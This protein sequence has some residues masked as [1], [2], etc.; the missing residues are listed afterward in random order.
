[1]ASNMREAA[2]FYLRRGWSVFPI[3]PVSK[4]P[5]VDW[6]EFQERHA[7]EREIDQWWRKFPSAGV[8]I[9]TGK[10]SGLV[11][12]DVDPK[13]GADVNYI[14]KTFPSSIVAK[15]GG[16]GGHFYYR[17]PEGEDIRNSVGKKNGVQTG[18]DVRANGGYVVAP[19]SLHPSGRRYEWLETAKKASPVPAKLLEMVQPHTELNGNAT[20]KEPWLADALRG[21]GEGARDDTA[22]RLAGY[23]L[24]K[25][26][27][28]DVVLETLRNWNDKNDPPL[29]DADLEKVVASVQKTRSRNPKKVENQGRDLEDSEQDPL[30]LVSLH[31]YMSEYGQYDV[32][33]AVEG[34]LP[35]KTIAMMVSP[36][37]TYKTWTLIDLAVSIA[38]GTP[39]LGTA[40]IN[41]PGP[42]LIYQQEDFHGQMAQRISTI[43]AARFD[44]G[45]S[46]DSDGKSFT[47]TLPPSPPIYLHDNRELRFD[48]K[49][50]MD[51]LE[52]R[53]KELHP[54][55]V[56]VDPLYTAA[57][58]DDYMAKAVPHMMRLKK[59]RDRY[60]C[61]FIIAHH[62]GK[63][64]DKDKL[65]RE[66]IWGSQFL[67]AFLET[68]WQ[69]RPKTQ[70][71]ALIRRH[72]KVT[73]D[74]EEMI[75]TFNISTDTFPTK[76]E[77][78][79]DKPK[80]NDD[81]Q[82]QIMEQLDAQGPMTAADLA[83]ATGLSRATISRQTRDM[84][85]T[86]VIRMGMDNKY[87][88]PEHF[89]VAEADD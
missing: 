42:V 19:P 73:K 58:M 54:V 6:Y 39:F 74:I 28:A 80:S 71:Q 14:Y 76:Y 85:S 68:G 16:G 57:P 32:S 38:T 20:S 17:Y 41:R 66:D 87:R 22:A 49:E 69:V 24:S 26:I 62:T 88:S 34:W 53:I 1:M 27:G 7:T 29:T 4:K 43:M 59:I 44:I 25:G 3:S 9:V 40:K 83:R 81:T 48:N 10:I 75:L 52:A 30:R 50:I 5:L 72:F 21:V 78:L 86:G 65:Q 8:G 51:I 47:V 12:L 18:Y 89:N 15:T 23:Y 31:Q 82:I 84:L 61:S 70:N 33:W 77:A 63:R 13:H 64:S 67:N 35:D 79:L 56:I 45:W 2:L 11:V 55:L 36:P 60:G 37:G 46:G